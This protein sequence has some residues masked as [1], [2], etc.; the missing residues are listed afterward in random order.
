MKKSELAVLNTTVFPPQ[1]IHQ[2]F[3]TAFTC[4]MIK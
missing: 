3:P 1:W 2:F 4:A